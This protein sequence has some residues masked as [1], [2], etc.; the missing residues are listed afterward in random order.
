MT[1]TRKG[2]IEFYTDTAGQHRWRIVA[3]NGK[4]LADSGQGYSRR[5]DCERGL[6][7]VVNEAKGWGR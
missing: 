1:T 2:K 4:T 6:S 7:R 3:S 5:I